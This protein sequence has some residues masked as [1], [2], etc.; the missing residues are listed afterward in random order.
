MTAYPLLRSLLGAYLH[1]DYDLDDPDPLEV[2][3]IGVQES[4]LDRLP[5]LLEEMEQLHAELLRLDPDRGQARI[6]NAIHEVRRLG[7]AGSR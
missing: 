5:P 6:A 2:M 7:A 4:F 3:V 1:R